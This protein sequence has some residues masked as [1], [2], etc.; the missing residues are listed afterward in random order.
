MEFTKGLEKR[1]NL[2]IYRIAQ[3]ACHQ[4][5]FHGPF[6]ANASWP[7]W[8]ASGNG[9]TYSVIG[10]QPLQ[11]TGKVAEVWVAI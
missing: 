1:S 10:R 4:Q 2:S 8:H 5:E 9:G 3:L 7:S 6:S 11:R